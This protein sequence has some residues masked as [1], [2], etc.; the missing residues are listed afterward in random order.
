MAQMVI[1]VNHTGGEV[2]SATVLPVHRVAF[3]RHF[4]VPFA[5]LRDEPYEERLVW[6]G[7]FTT[8]RGRPNPPGF[9]AWLETVESVNIS[10]SGGDAGPLDETASSGTSLPA[11]SSPAPGSR[12]TG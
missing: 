2:A 1:S 3:E 12:T 10:S 11:P 8:T 6:I 5:S 9:D 4:K 7:W